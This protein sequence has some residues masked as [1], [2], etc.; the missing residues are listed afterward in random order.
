MQTFKTFVIVHKKA[1]PEGFIAEG[2]TKKKCLTFCSR[3]LSMIEKQFNCLDRNEDVEPIQLH[4]LSFFSKMDKPLEKANLNQLIIDE[5]KQAHGYVLRNWDELQPLLEKIEK[6]SAYTVDF[7]KWVEDR[8][9]D[10]SVTEELLCLARGPMKSVIT[11]EDNEDDETLWNTIESGSTS[12]ILMEDEDDEEIH[13]VR[14]DVEPQYADL[15]PNDDQ[16]N[17]KYNDDQIN[18]LEAIKDEEEEEEDK[19]EEMLDFESSKDEL[20]Q[21]L[22]T[23]CDDDNDSSDE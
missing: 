5:R 15:N 23:I 3:Y 11:Y 12:L 21:D 19:E 13:L 10:E 2:Y 16:I 14:D 9:R 7:E 4:N 8:I 22:E 1:Y 6:E 20:D 18:D 17:E